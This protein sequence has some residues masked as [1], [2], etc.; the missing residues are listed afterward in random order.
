MAIKVEANRR[1]IGDIRKIG[2]KPEASD[3]KNRRQTGGI[4]KIGGKSVF[5]IRKEEISGGK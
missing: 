4:R 3:Q 2:G 1:Q 5:L